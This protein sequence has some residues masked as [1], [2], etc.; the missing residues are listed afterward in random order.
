VPE[1]IR[2]QIQA[3]VSWAAADEL[4][5]LAASHFLVQ[6]SITDGDNPKDLVLTIGYLPPPSFTGTPE[7][8]RDAVA[9]LDRVSVRPIARFSVPLGKATDLRDILAQMLEVVEQHARHQG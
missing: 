2:S 9:T 8:V 6:T 7:E 3:Q 5:V 4:P 1:P